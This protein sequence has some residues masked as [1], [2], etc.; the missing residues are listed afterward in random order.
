[1]AHELDQIEDQIP[2][3]LRTSV[4]S[5][6][7]QKLGGE[8][9]GHDVHHLRRVVTM[10]LRLVHATWASAASVGHAVTPYNLR[11][12]FVAAYVHDLID[13]KVAADE[14][15]ER[16][17]LREFLSAQ[18]LSGEEIDHIFFIIEHMSYSK[19]LAERIELSPEGKIVQ[20]ADRLDAL[21]TIGIARAIYY[22]GHHHE[23]LYDPD[24]APRTFK[25]E[26]DY[27]VPGT[28]MNHF[29]EKLFKLEGLMNTPAARAIAHERTE[30]M[31]RFVEA[32]IEEWRA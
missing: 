20:D 11:V 13:P 9:S 3:D 19:N 2:S 4:A 21:G 6:V 10:A 24:I 1:M 15:Q 16:G 14:D 32:F 17:E 31:R 23:V 7:E 26:A 5:F 25:T 8:K 18:D 30:V 27:R 28:V 12:I 22:G 29:E